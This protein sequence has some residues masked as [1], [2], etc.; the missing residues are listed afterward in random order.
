MP[1]RV[2]VIAEELLWNQL[3]EF[4]IKG[5]VGF[6]SI[7]NLEGLEGKLDSFCPE[8]I[9]LDCYAFESVRERVFRWVEDT[10]REWVTHGLHGKYATRS[11]R[12]G[13]CVVVFL[14]HQ[15]DLDKVKGLY[16]EVEVVDV[17]R[18]GIWMEARLSVWMSSFAQ[19]VTLV[20]CS[21]HQIDLILFSDQC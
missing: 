13:I 16:K 15:A 8:V 3:V 7:S 18:L 11:P 20:T 9:V 2:F 6:Q 21:G 5:V 19:E 12:L 4:G 14:Q 17:D 10:E 1:K